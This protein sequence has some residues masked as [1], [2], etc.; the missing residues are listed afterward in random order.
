MIRSHTYLKT[1]SLYAL[2]R[3]LL[4]I[5]FWHSLHVEVG[6]SVNV[7]HQAIKCSL[8][9]LYWWYWRY[10][11]PVR[12][13]WGHFFL[14]NGSQRCDFVWAESLFSFALSVYFCLYQCDRIG[15]ILKG[16]GS[17]FCYKSSQ[18]TSHVLALYLKGVTFLIDCA[19][20][21]FWD[22]IW[23]KLGYFLFQHLVTLDRT[24][25]K[26]DLYFAGIGT[27]PISTNTFI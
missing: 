13:K 12:H 8:I 21:T 16:L 19:V 2:L 11:I 26:V 10:W 25:I 1:F 4:S 22:N 20:V 7:G 14:S 9:I 27:A 5:S 23:T 6:R 15:L 18:N 3:S 24:H 17:K